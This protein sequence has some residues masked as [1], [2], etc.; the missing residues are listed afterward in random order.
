MLN[1]LKEGDLTL[2]QKDIELEKENMNSAKDKA[3]TKRGM[4]PY[5][6]KLWIYREVPYDIR[7]SGTYKYSAGNEFKITSDKA[8]SNLIGDIRLKT[9][10][11][12]MFSIRQFTSMFDPMEYLNKIEIC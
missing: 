10:I 8:V 4:I 7:H 5:A 2:D 3:L 11:Q 9:A 12:K 1:E 6:R